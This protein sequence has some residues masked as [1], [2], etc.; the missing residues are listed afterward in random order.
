MIYLFTNGRPPFYIHLNPLRAKIVADLNELDRYAYCG[1]S[2]LMG[3]KRKWQNGEFVL[4]LF[5]KRVAE[6]RRNYR[7]YVKK[8]IEMGRRPELVGGGLIR[9]LGGWD[10]IN[11]LERG[12]SLNNPIT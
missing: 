5:G 9:S 10:E 11:I 6:A 1:H 7:A 2:A 8:G 3:K 4:G 12:T